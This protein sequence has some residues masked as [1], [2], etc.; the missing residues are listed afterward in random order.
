[1]ANYK[2]DEKMV[3]SMSN[4]DKNALLSLYLLSLIHI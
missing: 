4:G 3:L 1:M 2:L